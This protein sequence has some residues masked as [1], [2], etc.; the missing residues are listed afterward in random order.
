MILRAL[1]VWLLLVVVAIANGGFRVAVLIPRV[2]EQTGHVISTILLSVLILAI[3]WLT[4]GWIAPATMSDAIVIGFFWAALT[5]LFEFGAG[6]FLFHQPW[7]RLLAD[8][9]L[10][11]GRIWIFVL[12]IT[13]KAPA[14]AARLRGMFRG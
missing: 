6:H 3:A 5:L 4:I 2:G 7:E 8:Y 9:N 1:A 11:K 13:L 12:I 10:R 14:I